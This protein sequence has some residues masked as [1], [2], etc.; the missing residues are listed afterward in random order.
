[1]VAPVLASRM[2]WLISLGLFQDPFAQA[3]ARSEVNW[4]GFEGIMGLLFIF[5]IIAS[6][7]LLKR[8]KRRAYFLM[9]VNVTFFLN[10]VLFFTTGK[11]E[12]YSQRALIDFCKERQGEDCYVSTLGMKSYA[13]LFY[14]QKP[15]P[16]NPESLDLGW[17]LKGE[18]DKPSY[19][20][21]RSK[22]LEQF[23]KQYP[24]LQLI[25]EKNGFSFCLREVN[26]PPEAGNKTLNA[27]NAVPDA[28][29]ESP[30]S[31]IE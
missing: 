1:M 5:G 23:Q 10:L 12:T 20:I 29:N 24:D 3:N 6:L 18:I 28:E 9:F 4:T 14:T 11:I 13:H 17:L 27:E 7:I 8:N 15:V 25:Y 21:L 19:F 22:T 31:K 26:P 30:A 16:D 2:D